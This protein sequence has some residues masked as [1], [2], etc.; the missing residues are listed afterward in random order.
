MREA[1]P[2][3]G[4]K[5]VPQPPPIAGAELAAE[6]LD[7]ATTVYVVSIDERGVPTGCTIER[8]SGILAIDEAVCRAAMKARFS[9]RTI[10]GR[11]VAGTYRDAFVFLSN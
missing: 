2:L 1:V 11:A 3:A 8:P 9:P 5:I 4:A 6:G 10:N 7:A